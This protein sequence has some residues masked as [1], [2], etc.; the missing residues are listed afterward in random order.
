MRITS[1][2]PSLLVICF[3]SFFQG[4]SWL[5]V[6][7]TRQQPSNPHRLS[8]PSTLVTT[9]PQT[10]SSLIHSCALASLFFPSLCLAPHRYRQPFRPLRHTWAKKYNKSSELGSSRTI[11]II[12]SCLSSVFIKPAR[13]RESCTMTFFILPFALS[14]SH[15]SLFFWVLCF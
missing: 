3:P 8:R 1:T 7:R 11:S 2:S 12:L 9:H 14:R 6:C 10:N 15:N 13:T 5:W 4:S